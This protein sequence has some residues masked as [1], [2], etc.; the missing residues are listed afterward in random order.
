[1][2]VDAQLRERSCRC[3]VWLHGLRRCG[4]SISIEAQASGS[5]RNSTFVRANESLHAIQHCWTLELPEELP[6]QCFIGSAELC[7]PRKFDIQVSG[8]SP[9][10][11]ERIA[12]IENQHYDRRQKDAAN[13]KITHL[14][15]GL[16]NPHPYSRTGCRWCGN[17]RHNT[18]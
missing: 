4:K 9:K 13:H 1:M 18:A 12:R 3:I 16:D 11:L 8:Y 15:Q 2:I 6:S 14:L 5:S 10:M 17:S 7:T